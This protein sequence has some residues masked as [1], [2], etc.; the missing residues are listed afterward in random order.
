VLAAWPRPKTLRGG[1]RSAG[2]VEAARCE[3]VSADD[4]ELRAAVSADNQNLGLAQD[5]DDGSDD[6]LDSVAVF[7]LSSG[8]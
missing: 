6:R 2:V 7:D 4:L 5:V 3:V 1:G 8:L